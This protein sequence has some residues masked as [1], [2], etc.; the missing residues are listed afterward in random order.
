MPDYLKQKF[1]DIFQEFP[2]GS[3]SPKFQI[4]VNG[5]SFGPG[6]VFQKGVSF[7]GIDFQLYK[8]KDIAVEKNPD[9][10]LKILGFYKE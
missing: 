5:I 7:G 1:T 4:E 9:G 10:S 8:Y 3:L 6:V 2:D